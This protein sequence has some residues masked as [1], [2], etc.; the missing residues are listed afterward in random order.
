[1]KKFKFR[2]WQW[3]TTIIMLCQTM[4]SV[5]TPIIANAAEIDHPQTV[6]VQY[7][8]NKLY[9]VTGKYTNGMD[10]SSHTAPTFVNY[11]GNNQ[12]VF[13]IDPGIPIPNST[14]PGYEKNPLPSMSEK[15]K[16]ISVLNQ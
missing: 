5:F 12:L 9:Y 10:F 13:C 1:M 16:L 14:T 2:K 7:D 15:A 6:T 8:P 4:I 11:N 3:V